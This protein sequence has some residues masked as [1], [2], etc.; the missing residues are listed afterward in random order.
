MTWLEEEKDVGDALERRDE[1]PDPERSLAALQELEAIDRL[2]AR[3][4]LLIITG[5]GDGLSAE[6]R[7]VLVCLRQ[8]TIRRD[9]GCRWIYSSGGTHIMSVKIKLARAEVTYF[10]TVLAAFRAGVNYRCR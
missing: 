2:F 3:V 4:A 6:I 9:G 8:I 10:Y 1:F 5:L 7:T